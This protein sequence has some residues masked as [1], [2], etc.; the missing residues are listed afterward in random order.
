MVFSKEDKV[1]IKVLS[2]EKDSGVE[3]V[4]QRVPNRN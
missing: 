1:A 3:K 2:Q 4:H